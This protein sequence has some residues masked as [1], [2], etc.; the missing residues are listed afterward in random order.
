MTLISTA[1]LVPHDFQTLEQNYGLSNAWWENEGDF[2]DDGV[3]NWSDLPA[4][5][6]PTSTLP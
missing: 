2:N 5:C 6:G 4:C 1:M 3:V